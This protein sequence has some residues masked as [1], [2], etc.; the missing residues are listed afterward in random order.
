MLVGKVRHHSVKHAVGLNIIAVVEVVSQDRG[1]RNSCLFAAALSAITS[2]CSVY[3]GEAVKWC[4]LALE[5][6]YMGACLHGCGFA[7]QICFL[8]FVQTLN[9]TAVLT[10]V[11]RCNAALPYDTRPRT[12]WSI[13]LLRCTCRPNYDTPAPKWIIS[14]R[15]VVKI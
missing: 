7:F 5:C 13:C 9:T 11:S 14:S 4:V 2:L 1:S 12:I 6:F 3:P 10:N 8:H 15:I